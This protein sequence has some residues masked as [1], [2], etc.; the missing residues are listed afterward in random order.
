MT[1]KIFFFAFFIV[2]LFLPGRIF[3]E[4]FLKEEDSVGKW[5]YS[6][7][8]S[9]FFECVTF[10]LISLAGVKLTRTA[11][12]LGDIGLVALFGAIYYLANNKEKFNLSNPKKKI[13]PKSKVKV[14]S[15]K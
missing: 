10:I 8:F 7:V 11:Y 13:N 5:F 1:V 12:V 15:K 9:F 3:V 2:F 14:S 4:T 6:A